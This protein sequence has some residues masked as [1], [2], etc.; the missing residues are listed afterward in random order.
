MDGS[1]LSVLSLEAGIPAEILKPMVPCPSP[2]GIGDL[3][4]HERSDHLGALQELGLRSC[5][6]DMHS[7][8]THYWSPLLGLKL[9]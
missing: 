4:F 2:T 6:S 1:A 3:G 7:V 9:S 8:H 5:C